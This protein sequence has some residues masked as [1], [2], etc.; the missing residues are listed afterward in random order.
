MSKSERIKMVKCME[1]IACQVNDEEVQAA[2]LYNGVADGDIKYGDLTDEDPDGE[3]EWYTT[4]E[5]FADLMGCFLRMMSRARKSGGL[6]CDGVV[7][8]LDN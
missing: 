8:S 3:V 4:D 5:H 1:Y 6:F 7:D 2:W